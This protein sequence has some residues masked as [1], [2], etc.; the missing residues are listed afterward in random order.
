[1]RPSILL[2]PEDKTVCVK[3]SCRVLG[4]WTVIVIATLALPVFREESANVP[5]GQAQDHAA[6]LSQS[7]AG[8]VDRFTNKPAAER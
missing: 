7:P 5:R 1:M 6:V 2:T 4:I 8:A 3:W